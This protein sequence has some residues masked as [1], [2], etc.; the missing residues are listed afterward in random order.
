MPPPPQKKLIYLFKY[1]GFS[2]YT[3]AR[4]LNLLKCMYSMFEKLLVKVWRTCKKIDLANQ[5]NDCADI[6]KKC[7]VTQRQ[8]S[9]KVKVT[10]LSRRDLD[11]GIENMLCS[12]VIT[13]LGRGVVGSLTTAS[14]TNT[15]AHPISASKNSRNVIC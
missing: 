11:T 3:H 2:Y 6:I 14:V 12:G 9:S 10:W 1:F 7:T 4:I 8:V 5:V 15:S 13:V